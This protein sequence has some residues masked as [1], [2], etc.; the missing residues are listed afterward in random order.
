MPLI[1]SG[2]ESKRPG[3]DADALAA[4][5]QSAIDA[6]RMGVEEKARA[7]PT[8][9]KYGV[10]WRCCDCMGGE[11]LGSNWRAEVRDCSMDGQ[12]GRGYCG[13]WPFRPGRSA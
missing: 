1:E 8:S 5:R 2:T 12:E 3:R 11:E 9:W 4:I 13:L 7:N 10:R 6:P